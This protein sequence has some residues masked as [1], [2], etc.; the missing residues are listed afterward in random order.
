MRRQMRVLKA[1]LWRAL[2]WAAVLGTFAWLLA[3]ARVLPSSSAGKRRRLAS[4]RRRGPTPRLPAIPP[5][6]EIAR[7]APGLF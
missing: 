6:P 4:R 7:G 2:E 3:H 1:K 5:R